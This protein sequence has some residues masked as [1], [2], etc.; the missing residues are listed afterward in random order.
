MFV[1]P[2]RIPRDTAENLCESFGACAVIA[3]N[4]R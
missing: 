1:F 2:F 4:K 3:L